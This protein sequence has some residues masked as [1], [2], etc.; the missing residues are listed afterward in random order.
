MKRI[1]IVHGWGGSPNE[2]LHKWLK[3]ELER[4]DYAIH[5]PTMPHTENPTIEEWVAH[6][7]QQVGKLDAHTYFIGHS[8]GCQAILRYLETEKIACGGV[9]FIAGWFTL[10][11][12]ETPEEERIAAPWLETP[13]DYDK[14]K[15]N[16]SQ[17][18]AIFSDNDPFVPL[19]DKEIFRAKLGSHIIVEHDK[20]HFA[21]GETLI[22]V[23]AAI[24]AI[25]AFSTSSTSKRL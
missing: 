6:L 19:S 8:I 25:R 23:P 13:I 12:L 14:V 4:G 21:E 18:V 7:S 11:G 15:K 9:V 24:R 22:T 1:F 2:V 3:S 5:V 20:G 16:L 10:Q 17:S